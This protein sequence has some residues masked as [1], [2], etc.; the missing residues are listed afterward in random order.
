MSR[1]L[2]ISMQIGGRTVISQAN[3]TSGPLECQRA[4]SEIARERGRGEAKVTAI[5]HGAQT[6]VR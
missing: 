6:A 5:C 3:H 4:D 2:P 1:P